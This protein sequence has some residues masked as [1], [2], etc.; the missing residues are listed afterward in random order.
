MFVEIGMLT[1]GNY[2]L[3]KYLNYKYDKFEKNFNNLVERIPGLSNN[4][5]ESLKMLDYSKK[6]YGYDLKLLLPQG[7]SSAKLEENLLT[8]KEGLRLPTTNLNYDNGIFT[9]QAIKHYKNRRFEPLKL[10]PNEI[11]IAEFM[12]EN[13]IV[14]QNKF[15]HALI[16]G[17]TG[18]G[19][20][21]ILFT[22]LT[23]LINTSKNKVRLYLLQIRKSDLVLFQNCKQ[24]KSCSRTLE[25]ALTA[26]QEVDKELQRRDCLLD[27]EKGYLNIHEYNLKSGN[28]LKYIYVF[29]EEF[30]FL[31]KSN[32]DTKQEKAIKNECM[33]YIKGI[34]NVGRSSG[35]FLITSLQ[36]PTADSIPSDI[37]AMLTTRIALNIKDSSTCRVVM[38]ND[39]AVNL[40]ERQLVCRTKGTVLGYSLTIDFADI[41]KYTKDFIVEKKPKE[42][43]SPIKPKTE[44]SDDI[45]KL[46]GI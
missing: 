4:K 15:P 43:N 12:G 38:D 46:L 9:L 11:L 14:D 31:N 35:V 36:K 34:V 5:G 29:I 44:N 45:I 33:K 19:K 22:I 7:I 17:D 25:E 21:R 24:V 37:K 40:D 2:A 41:K 13:I 10:K 3:Y 42:K 39:S 20:S 26:L 8:L 23:N 18:T 6:E 16:C 32:A 27:I 28:T 30:S 1:G